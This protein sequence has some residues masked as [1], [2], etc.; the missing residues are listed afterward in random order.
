MFTGQRIVADKYCLRSAGQLLGFGDPFNR[1]SHWNGMDSS[2]G[3]A[4]EQP[5]LSRHWLHTP[6]LPPLTGC[7]PVRRSVLVCL[8][9]WLE[10]LQDRGPAVQLSQRSA[11]GLPGPEKG[12]A[13]WFWGSE[14]VSERTNQGTNQ[15]MPKQREKWREAGSLS[16]ILINSFFQLTLLEYLLCIK[17]YRISKQ[18]L[19]C[20]W[21]PTT[22]NWKNIFQRKSVMKQMRKSDNCGLLSFHYPLNKYTFYNKVLTCYLVRQLAGWIS[23]WAWEG[24]IHSQHTWNAHGGQGHLRV[25]P[26]THLPTALGAM[27]PGSRHVHGWVDIPRGVVA[28]SNLFFNNRYWFSRATPGRPPQHRAVSHCDKQKNSESPAL[29]LTRGSGEIPTLWAILA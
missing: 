25:G 21:Q 10:L 26:A 2:S 14:Q 18:W 8:P 29:P 28:E 16:L 9:I 3:P 1:R 19:Q 27:Q 13:Q 15:W 11:Q 17:L 20:A 23:H 4:T 5:Q 12:G 22:S 6:A 24:L 7:S